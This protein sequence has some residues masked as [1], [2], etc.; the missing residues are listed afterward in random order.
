MD[1]SKIDID[2]F[3]WEQPHTFSIINGVM[4]DLNLMGCGIQGLTA[5]AIARNGRRWGHTVCAICGVAYSN[6]NIKVGSNHNRSI[7]H[8]NAVKGRFPIQKKK[9]KVY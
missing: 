3:D 9:R 2:N 6:Q 1:A 8:Q 7:R 4:M 5:Y